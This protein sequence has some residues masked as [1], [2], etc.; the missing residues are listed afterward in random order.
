ML[1]LIITGKEAELYQNEP[2]NL[3]YQFTDVS[4]INASKSNFSKTFRLPM[5]EAN[6]EIFGAVQ[7]LSVVT[8]FN[9]KL[10]MAASILDGSI[11]LMS[12][13]V[14]VKAFYKQKGKYMD[15]ECVFFGEVSDLSKKV[16]D[17]MLSDLDLSAYDGTMTVANVEATWAAASAA[18]RFGV[19]D[20]G[21]NWA[22]TYR[23]QLGSSASLIYSRRYSPRRG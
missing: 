7:E 20:R 10:K 23:I 16:G 22:G 3:T 2:V 8:T 21:Q 15:V 14:Q 5:T 4:Q 6:Q 11:P 17:D 9:P 19:V 18:I 12:G 13:Y 1:R